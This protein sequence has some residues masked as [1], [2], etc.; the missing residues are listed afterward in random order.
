M[1]CRRGVASRP[2]RASPYRSSR[3]VRNRWITFFAQDFLESWIDW[4]GPCICSRNNCSVSNRRRVRRR[5]SRPIRLREVGSW[6]PN[7]M[8][9]SG[10][11]Q[12]R[13]GYGVGGEA[14]D[15]HGLTPGVPLL[16]SRSNEIPSGVDDQDR[17]LHYRPEAPP[18]GQVRHRPAIR[19]AAHLQPDLHGLRPNSRVLHVAQGY[20]A[21]GGLPWRR[22]GMQRP[23]D[24]D[25][26]RRTA[27]LSADRSACKRPPRAKTD[28]LHLHERDVHAQKDA[29]MAGSA[30]CR[31]GL[32]YRGRKAS[33]R[34][35]K[36]CH[37]KDA[38][39]VRRVRKI[40]P[41]RPLVR[42]AGCIGT[43]TSTASNGR[44]I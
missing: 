14:A 40:R 35:R 19:A 11:I 21:P 1:Y 15:R 37:E 31:S 39:A 28:R 2:D 34:S 22:R 23:D 5:G 18:D 16:L 9:P 12:R 36:A 38:E 42:A 8:L 33:A 24:L 32:D 26:R 20:Y 17:R 29:R 6:H 4:E 13:L 44:T 3:R 27:D 7:R 30:N 10:R 25:L 41:S 43:S